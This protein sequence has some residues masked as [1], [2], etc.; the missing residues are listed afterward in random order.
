MKS[1]IKEWY[2]KTYPTDELG[3]EID[4]SITFAD[5]LLGIAQCAEVYDIIGVSDS[6][7]RE[8]IFAEIAS[9]MGC[10]YNVIFNLWLED[11]L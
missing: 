5:V 6:I 2:C 11:K 1:N 3:R 4:G 10:D 8:R 9:R 7:I